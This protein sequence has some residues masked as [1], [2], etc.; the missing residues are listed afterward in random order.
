MNAPD[1]AP[2]A[3]D[4]LAELLALSPGGPCR[5]IGHAPAA[6]GNNTGGIF[7][8]LLFG[9]AAAA[10]ALTVER[11]LHMMAARFSRAGAPGK[12]I[13]YIV[14]EPLD[15]GSFSSRRITASQGD[16]LL[17]EFNASF[18]ADE[19][20]LDFDEGWNDPPAPE[21]L[22][23][24]AEA[25]A[26]FDYLPKPTLR[27]LSRMRGL[28]IRPIEADALLSPGSNKPARIWVRVRACLAARPDL[29]APAV[30]HLSDAM[31][32]GPGVARHTFILNPDFFG[33]TLSHTL[34]LHR[35]ADP[36]Q[37]LFHE[38]ACHWTGGGRTLNL[39]RLYTRDGRLLAT[40]AQEALLRRRIPRGEAA[41]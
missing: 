5:W 1:N 21:G 24:L 39:G 14:S 10:A 3:T 15:G 32:A 29:W 27:A 20:G 28:E 35:Q 12:S 8:G 36:S 37:W 25:A 11:P 34:W 41:R 17:A 23:T 9:Q 22:P 7:G 2:Q 40:N 4:D 31:M 16:R 38:I 6:L 26:E 30:G 19:P 18:Q 33:T 13:D